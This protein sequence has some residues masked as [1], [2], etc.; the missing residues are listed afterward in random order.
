M[1]HATKFFSSKT[2][3]KR[4]ANN[5]NWINNLF[6]FKPKKK[7]PP[8]A[9]PRP[10]SP[11]R[12]V[13]VAPPRPRSLHRAVAPPIAPP[14]APAKRVHN[15]PV[16]PTHL[17]GAAA[18]PPKAIDFDLNL[19]IQEMMIH[20]DARAKRHETQA[21]IDAHW[22]TEI[23]VKMNSEN[24]PFTD[25]DKKNLI[26]MA[27]AYSYEG[28]AKSKVYLPYFSKNYIASQMPMFRGGSTKQERDSRSRSP[29]RVGIG[30]PRQT[31]KKKSK[32]KTKTKTKSKSKSKSKGKQ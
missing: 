2:K 25:D 29:V 15:F 19:L 32:T 16:P 9:P 27:T 20:I 12:A 1:S 6:G 23:Y 7:S 13:A 8:R 14:R 3:T 4:K 22:L 31:I 11:R 21:E 26:A 24:N 30:R 17:P 28:N 5:M 18:P 10:I